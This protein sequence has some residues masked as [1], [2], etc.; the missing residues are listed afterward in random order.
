MIMRPSLLAAATLLLSP[1]SASAEPIS[2]Q[3]LITAEH[4]SETNIARN[5]ARNPVETLQFFGLKPDMTV[6]EILPGGGWYTEILAPYLRDDGTYYAAHFSPDAPLAYQAPA[7]E[8]FIAKLKAEPEIYDKTIIT[9][10]N[11]PSETSIAPPG[12]ADMALTFR[13]V[14]NWIMASNEEQYF[15]AFYE[16]LKP[17]GI[18]GVVE[19]RAAAGSA[20]EVMETTGY[21]TQDYVIELARNAGFEFVESAEINANALDPKNHPRGVWTL[22]P[23]LRLGDTDRE[24]YIAIGESDRMTLKFIK[25]L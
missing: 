20:I 1:L 12:S 5:E 15:A 3:Q 24:K 8:A 16:A 7:L 23:T 14:H 6:I 17:G 18:L 11:P 19:H 10:L 25:P 22:P 2:L 9:H 13:N 21:V 4:R